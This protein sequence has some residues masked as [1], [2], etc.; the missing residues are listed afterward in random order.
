MTRYL[1]EGGLRPVRVTSGMEAVTRI[2]EAQYEEKMPC[3]LLLGEELSDLPVLEVAAH[4]RQL[5]GR[6]F[7]ILLVSE[8]DW[9]QIEYRAQRAGVNAF[10]PC[11][12]FKSRLFA[13]LS[14]LAQESRQ[15]KD[16]Y[17]DAHADY[18]KYRVLLVE[19][20]E[21]NQ[22]IALELLEM[23]GIQA[24]AAD[25]GAMAVQMF[26]KSPEG[27]YDLIFMDIQMPV[28]DGYGASRK[29][30]ALSRKDAQSV[31]IVAMTANAFAEDIRR[32][33]EA[34]MDE[35]LSKPVDPRRLEE[36]LQKRLGQ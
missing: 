34:G 3:A 1:Q 13:A 35:H 17:L 9:P 16:A 21:L 14:E 8:A 36:I 30:R 10:V 25:N 33:R 18:S 20:N 32:S 26:E 19:D 7:P 28:L 11:P 22:E 27:Y 12:L 2:T 31:C 23:T 29:I 6:D 4:V 24:E 5:A 15:D